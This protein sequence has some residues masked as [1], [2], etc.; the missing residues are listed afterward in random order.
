MVLP[1]QNAVLPGNLTAPGK[2]NPIIGIG[3]LCTFMYKFYKPG[4]D[5][6]PLVLITD[7]NY[8]NLYCRGINIHY[9]TFPVIKQLL[10]PQGKSMCENSQLTYQYI[11][12]D[13]FLVSAFRQYKK[14]GIQSLKKL[15]CEFIVNAMAVSR[16]FDPNEIESIR[17]SVREQI[18][19]IINPPAEASE[20]LPL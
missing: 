9:L 14:N 7:P 11:K 10:F 2:I 15:N 1:F 17:K 8:K 18:R 4:H 19:K 6:Q 13:D 20:E 16:S 12:G 3:S 5:P